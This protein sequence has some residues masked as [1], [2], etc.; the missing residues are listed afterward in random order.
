MNHNCGNAGTYFVIM[1]YI[2]HLHLISFLLSLYDNK[3]FLK[4]CIHRHRKFKLWFKCMESIWKDA[5]RQVPVAHTCNPSYLGGWDWEYHGSRPAQ[6]NSL[7]DTISN[8]TR[9]K[10]T[11]GVAQGVEC[12]L[13]KHKALSSNLI[14]TRKKDASQVDNSGDTLKKE[15]RGQR[16][17]FR[18]RIVKGG[19]YII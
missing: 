16:P 6:A 8:I 5:S 7:W 12:L 19:F 15:G 9:A 2:V 17:G 18:E 13:C 10:W 3:M 14:P 1:H 4:A 11:G